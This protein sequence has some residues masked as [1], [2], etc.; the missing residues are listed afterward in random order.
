VRRSRA[1]V[2]EE[3][4]RRRASFRKR[5][6]YLLVRRASSFSMSAAPLSPLWRRA[7]GSDP[8]TSRGGPLVALAM[9][10]AVILLLRR[11][12]GERAPLPRQQSA[13]PSDVGAGDPRAGGPA[14]SKRLVGIGQVGVRTRPVRAGRALVPPTG[15]RLCIA[16]Q[17]RFSSCSSERASQAF[18]AHRARSAA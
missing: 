5:E 7:R 15:S 11:R 8:C 14:R 9:G 2:V 1:V 13:V 3:E 4:E 10:G 12:G 16:G 17:R 18:V 6:S